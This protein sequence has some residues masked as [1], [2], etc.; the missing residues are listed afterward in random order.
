ME[1]LPSG[2]SGMVPV[3]LLTLVITLAS[4]KKAADPAA[5]EALPTIIITEGGLISKKLS[6]HASKLG[7][8]EKLPAD[9]QL[10]FGTLGMRDHLKALS[11]T[12]YF[13]E[14][15][16]FL[17]DKTPAPSADKKGPSSKWLAPLW[18][19]DAFIALGK[20]GAETLTLL[21]QMA[22]QKRET[23]YRDLA[24]IGLESLLGA[25]PIPQKKAAWDGMEKAITALKVPTIWIGLR[26]DDANRTLDTLVPEHQRAW[27][28][29]LGTEG[30]ITLADG[31]TFAMREGTLGKLFPQPSDL[32]LPMLVSGSEVGSL[33]QLHELLKDKPIAV[34]WGSMGSYALLIISGERPQLEFPLHA[35]RSLLGRAEW[36]GLTPQAE[37]P[38]L[39]LGWADKPILEAMRTSGGLANTLSA[40]LGDKAGALKA[41]LQKLTEKETALFHTETASLAMAAWWQHGLNVE[42][43]GGVS[44]QA[45]GTPAKL[46]HAELLNATNVLFGSAEVLP[47]DNSAPWMDYLDTLMPVVKELGWLALEKKLGGKEQANAIR[48]WLEKEILPPLDAIGMHLQNV[49]KKG[50]GDHRAILLTLGTAAPTAAAAAATP[51]EPHP[52]RSPALTYLATVKDRAA[53]GQDW[54]GIEERINVLLKAFP[55]PTATEWPSQKA[56]SS[57]A[58]SVYPAP[59]WIPLPYLA[60]GVAI[61]EDHLLLSTSSDLATELAASW[62]GAKGKIQ[63][64]LASSWIIRFPLLRRMLQETTV[65][66]EQAEGLKSIQRWLSPLGDLQATT[67]LSPEGRVQR[68][69]SWAMEDPKRFD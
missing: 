6:T 47:K 24:A 36:D 58:F 39:G 23:T 9:T 32:P 64:A 14:L 59:Q 11:A 50:I 35:D 65:L 37:K 8:A 44:P 19:D 69:W 18:T 51:G 15:S 53:L 27:W 54:D 16:A 49:M 28:N 3:A 38:L 12:S 20:G 26:G 17:D 46:A 4:C 40:L 13:D 29:Q 57:G 42:L 30:K 52:D 31:N 1:R 62:P 34:A 2:V 60:P 7:F 45:I 43:H 25:K 22:Q 61:S 66:P 67:T 68:R 56:M 21:H 5:T 48:P 41:Q 10:F 33:D 55:L 63:P